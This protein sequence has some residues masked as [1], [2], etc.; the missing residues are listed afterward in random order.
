M[1]W[2]FFHQQLQW[3]EYMSNM[4]LQLS[5]YW[6]KTILLL[7]PYQALLLVLFLVELLMA[8]VP[9]MPWVYMPCCL[10]LQ[11][12]PSCE[13]FRKVMNRMYF[14]KKFILAHL[15]HLTYPHPNGLWYIAD[16]LLIPR[17]G[18][19]HEDLFCF[20]HDTSG[21]FGTDKSYAT[22]WDTY[23][24][25]NMCRDLEKSYIPSCME[26]LQI[27]LVPYLMSMS[28]IASCP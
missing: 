16:C 22:L 2:D 10:L 5:I 6:V 1:Q 14:A 19:I 23:Y 18:S 24:W 28:L 11:I 4:I 9:Q 3:Q 8:L 12:C 21:H 27:L 17:T 13:V 25:P 26:C 20:T 7:M 15:L